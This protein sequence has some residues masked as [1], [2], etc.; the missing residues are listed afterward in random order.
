[1]VGARLVLPGPHLDGEN[2]YHLLEAHACTISAGGARTAR[3]E[4]A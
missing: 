3:G 2:V 4:G 1:M